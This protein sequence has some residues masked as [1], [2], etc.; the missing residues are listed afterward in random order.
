MLDGQNNPQEMTM[1][2]RLDI[3]DIKYLKERGND[4]EDEIKITFTGIDTGE[5]Y[6]IAF[7]SIKPNNTVA[8][9]A[10]DLSR[11]NQITLIGSRELLFSI[12]KLK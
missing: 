11:Q 4:P 7:G 2:E 10:G 5:R 6:P 9:A 1:E 3:P 12:V 8:F